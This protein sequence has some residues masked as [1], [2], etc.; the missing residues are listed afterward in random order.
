MAG[1]ANRRDP[2]PR[3][4]ARVP[5]G[6]VLLVAAASALGAIG[7][8]SACLPDLAALEGETTLPEGAAPPFVGCG[9]GVIATLDDGGD[10]GESCDPGKANDIDAQAAGCKACQ[11]TCEGTL[12]PATHHC[13]FA[14]GSD[15]DY[16]DAR[17]RCKLAGAHV[18]TFASPA[19][20]AIVAGIPVP[21]ADTGYW[22]GLSRSST[23]S[24]A[25]GPDPS[26]AEEP[27]FPYPP[28]GPC[29]GCFG[30]GADGGVFPLESVDAS[31]PD[32]LVARGGSWFQVAC[33]RGASRTTICER[34]PAGTRAQALIGGFSFTLPSSAG[35]KT[36]LVAI[37]GADPDQAAQSCAGLD[38]GSLVVFGSAEEREQL[39]HE[40]LALDP[41]AVEQQLWI[42]LVQDGGAW[43]W[44][45]GV[46]AT[47]GGSRPLPW[48]NAQPGAASGS[49]A[50]MRLAA[51]AY[52]T[53]LAY[54]DDGGRAPRLY[55]C[56]RPA[57]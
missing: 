46:P 19:E 1:T 21:A 57:P 55:V 50:F 34:E 4:S 39:A 53:Q 22:V 54:A 32:C 29:E 31:N 36:Y 38:G 42:G 35:K 51:T 41:T 33:S 16:T 13:Y 11:I 44:E 10:A 27:G 28:A 48:G 15:S 5:S 43:I 2:R 47:A 17:T 7:A 40:I 26:R 12:D 3:A 18:V 23:L 8:A 56:Q 30:L 25:Y 24:E 45:D 37:S 14:A 52:D 9:D 20:A 6:V 49:R